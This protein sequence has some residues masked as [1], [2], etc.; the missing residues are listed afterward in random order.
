MRFLFLH[1]LRSLA[2][3]AVGRDMQDEA[4]SQ[5]VH[6]CFLRLVFWLSAAT[7][8]MLLIGCYFW[9]VAI[10]ATVEY[11]SGNCDV[12][13]GKYVFL[14]LGVFWVLGGTRLQDITICARILISTIASA[15]SSMVVGIGA[16]VDGNASFSM[17][18]SS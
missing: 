8:L 5:Q 10:G 6:N 15:V 11:G 16:I 2:E 4:L 9:T 13:L 12:P 7:V 3:V 14:Q 1:A 18:S 17:C